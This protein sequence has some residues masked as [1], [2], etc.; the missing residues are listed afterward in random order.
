MSAQKYELEFALKKQ[1]TYEA[2]EFYFKRPKELK[3]DS[4]QYMKYSL[5]LQSP[6]DRGSSRYFTISSSPLDQEYITLTTRIIRSTFK[7]VLSEMKPGD[8]LKAFGPLGY[9]TLDLKS[10]KDKVFLA[11]GIGVTPYHSILKTIENNKNLPNITL[12]T[13]FPEARDAVYLKELKE[14]EEKNKSIRIIYSLT[15]EKVEGF[16]KGRISKELIEKYV[17]NYKACEFFIVG[18]EELEAAFIKLVKGMGVQE[19]NIFSENFPGY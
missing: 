18:S 10:K 9:F 12:I 15:R 11:G 2:F 8:K 14:I 19:D 13:S 7:I 6:D 17:P 3:F 4:G 16:E 5:D 1:L